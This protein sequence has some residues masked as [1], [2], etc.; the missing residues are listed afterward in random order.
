MKRKVLFDPRHVRLIDEQAFPELP[1]PL[2]T[3]VDQEVAARGLRAQNFA[4]AGNL[5]PLRSGFLRLSTGDGFWHNGR[6]KIGDEAESARI[7]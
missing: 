1:L 6:S 3:F 4:R 2:G 5:E 7:L